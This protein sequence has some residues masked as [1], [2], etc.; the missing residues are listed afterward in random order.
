M[1]FLRS[2][3]CPCLVYVCCAFSDVSVL[4]DCAHMFPPPPRFFFSFLALP[5]RNKF[6][7]SLFVISLS[8]FTSTFTGSFAV[9]LERRGTRARVC[10]FLSV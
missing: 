7:T 6:L 5:H 2:F 9:S 3:S 1:I 8:Y 10:C 4:V